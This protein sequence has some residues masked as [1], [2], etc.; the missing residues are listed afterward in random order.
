V[1]AGF[2]FSRLLEN[3]SLNYGKLR[4]A[5][6]QTSG[7]PIGGPNQTN[8]G[9][10]Q[11]TYYYGNSNTFNGVPVGTL[12]GAAGSVE[13]NMPTVP[14]FF[15]KPFTLTELELG[16]ELKFFNSRLGVDVDYFTRK[17]KHEIQ[18][19]TLS[20]ATGYSTKVVGTGSTQNQGVELQITGNPVRTAKFSWNISFNF[21]HVTN[22]ILQTDLTGNNLTLGTYRPLNATTAFVKGMAG[23]Q[24]MAYD[25]TYD[26]KGN[27]VVDGSGLPLSNGKQ[28]PFG[29]VLPTTY[30]GLRN[31]FTF[32]N[33]N[34]G[35]LVD[36]NYG[37]KILSATSYYTI[38]RGLNKMTLANRAGITTGVTASGAQ[39]TVQAT[40][41]DYYQRI[42]SIS[43][44]NVLNGDYIKLRQV[45][46]GYNF[47]NKQLGNIPL[48]EAIQ[49]SLVGRNLWTIMKRSPNIDPESNFT[50]SVKYAGIEGTSLPSTRTYGINVNFKFKK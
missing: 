6:A 18:N 27:V 23:P 36:Y 49:V 46:L 1:S 43:R 17:T 19:A 15:L 50:N 4:A 10:Y 28:L 34:L 44:N 20:E 45:T 7:E 47:T 38:Y 29:S 39:N 13:N 33:I 21:T 2:V 41:Q 31:D 8:S 12:N 32:G 25:Y 14:N 22:K 24:I 9:T 16:A 35:I 40:A 37:N 3:T 11:N 5:F 30:G 26:S 48:F 42:A